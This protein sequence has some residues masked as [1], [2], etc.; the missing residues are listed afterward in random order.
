MR[1]QQ[2][3]PPQLYVRDVSDRLLGLSD[4]N[5][6]CIGR[7]EAD[8]CGAAMSDVASMQGRIML[9]QACVSFVLSPVLGRM[10]GKA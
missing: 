1:T 7:M 10:S 2:Q 8:E 3:S 5:V 6:P 4:N 9:V